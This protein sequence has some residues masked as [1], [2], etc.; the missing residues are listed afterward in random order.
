MKHL[1]EALRGIADGYTLEIIRMFEILAN[2][3]QL[4]FTSD[5]DILLSEI[6]REL[7]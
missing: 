5:L 6:I 1:N 2:R 7:K 4:N 3:Q